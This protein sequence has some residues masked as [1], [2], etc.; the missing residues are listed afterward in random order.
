MEHKISMLPGVAEYPRNQWY[1]A[2]FSREVSR[3]FLKREIL[4]T[5]VV[6]YRTEAG[7]PVA[8]FDR[9]PHRGMP[10]S[11]GKLIGDIVQC[12]YHGFEFSTNG[13]CSSVPSGGPIPPKMCVSSFP[14]VEKWEWIWIWMG[15]PALA[16]EDLIPDHAA[17]GLIGDGWF[18]E[19]GIYLNVRANYLLP[20]EN[21]VDATHITYLHHGLIDTG[22]VAKHPYEMEVEGAI[23]STIRVFENETLPPMLIKVLGLSDDVRV[24]RTLKLSA[25]APNVAVIHL[26]FEVVGKSDGPALTNNLIVALTPQNRTATHQFACMAAGFPNPHPGRFDDL[27]NLLME[28]VV[29]IEEIQRL[30]DHLG[31]ENAPE[32]SV[33]SDGNAV[34]TRRILIDMLEKERMPVHSM[35][36]TADSVLK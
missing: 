21:L 5:P 11:S 13:K 15:D 31:E 4:D 35:T 17:L 22:N 28:D 30:F 36:A 32:V 1:V 16:N 9:C 25:F 29:A 6:M 14:L 24:N 23:V 19:A 7:A 20:F 2:A 26:N 18:S 10:F 12:G 3:E 27:R 34:R 33:K 8:L